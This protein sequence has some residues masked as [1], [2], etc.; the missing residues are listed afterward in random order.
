MLRKD[1]EIKWIPEAKEFFE[2]IK[3]ALVQA[4]I[5]ISPNHSKEFM[6]FSFASEDTIVV[7]LLQR[8]E[9]GHKRPNSFFSKNLRDSKLKYDIMEKHAYA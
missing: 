1:A 5:L 7:V 3:Q 6:I 2:N 4:P 9:Q 8:N